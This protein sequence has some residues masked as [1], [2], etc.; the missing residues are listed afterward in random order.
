MRTHATDMH[1][2]K[3]ALTDAV[4]MLLHNTRLVHFIFSVHT[5]RAIE[6]SRSAPLL[7]RGA[8]HEVRSDVG[9]VDLAFVRLPFVPSPICI[10][11]NLPA[12]AEL[13]SCHARKAADGPR[14]ERPGR[15]T[16]AGS[17][18]TALRA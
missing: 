17:P 10:D 1:S 13:P 8:A 12:G 18:P 14:A 2:Q 15:T 6:H 11:T 4:L 3:Q 16:Q 9:R 5:D 7:T